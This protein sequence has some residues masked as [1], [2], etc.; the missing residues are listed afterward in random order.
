[1]RQ[2]ELLIGGQDCK[3]NNG[4][5]FEVLAPATEEVYARA[6]QADKTDVDLAV[7][8]AQKGFKIWSKLAPKE[9]EA[10]LLRAADIVEQQGMARLL[11]I[12]IDESGSAI[13]KATFEIKYTVD[14]L[15]TAAGEV[16]RLYGETFPN[17]N[18][19]RISMV[20]RHPIG[21]VAVV[22]P[23]NAPLSLLTKMVAFPLA[24]GNSI[25]IK[26]SEQTP[27][28]AIE[29][30][31]IL[32]EAGI[33]AEAVSVVSG[34]GLEC[35]APL[36]EHPSV[37]CIALTGSTQTG[38]HIGAVA[39]K[40]MVRTQ[41]ELGGKSA[42]LVLKD[43]DPVKAANI[44]AQG[45][46]THGGQI[47]MANSRVIVAQEIYS[48]FIVALKSAA[49]NLK[50][51]DL[52]DPQTLYGPLINRAAV[53]KISQ[54][55]DE[56]IAAGAEILCGGKVLPYAN[57]QASL[58]FQPTVLL[59]SPLTCSAWRDESFGPLTNVLKARDLDHAIELANDS[60]FGLSACVLTKNINW[61]MRAARDID[62]G[63]VH[64]G[65]HSFQSNALAPIGGSKL[66][67]IGRS[68]GKYSTE[69][70]TEVKWVS[71]ELNET[72]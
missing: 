34:F 7:S 8:T 17:D 24:A 54:H 39:M 62:A 30:A 29:F 10:V 11:D 70:F 1:M 45:I 37:D 4:Q 12:L 5:Y 71:I 64:I 33:P 23:Y 27:T 60:Q 2:T 44:V 59:N 13:T 67:G 9:R 3:P 58:V 41:L 20:F 61:A 31:K 19:D 63:S 52:R 15:R 38:I 16:R 43:V 56:A 42:A 55:I 40:R 69:E 51:G 32:L 68:G 26:P 57:G 18:P 65:M 21:V 28:I 50:I 14:L 36:V 48:E 49:Q 35:G 53:D 46:F 25:V 66:S 6:A 22:S 47:C 72:L